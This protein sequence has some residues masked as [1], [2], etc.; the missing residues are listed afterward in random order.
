MSVDPNTLPVLKF[1]SR[2]AA[3]T[4]AKMAIN[5]WNA[6]GWNTTAVY[7][8]LFGPRVKDFQRAHH[9]TAD[10]VIGPATWKALIPH[11]SPAALLLLKPKQPPLVKPRQGF[12]S[13]VEDLWRPYTQGRNAGLS[14]LGTY[15]PASKL[16]SGKPSDHATSRLDGRIGEPACAFDLGFTPVTKNAARA[17]FTSMTLNPAVEYVIME[18]RIWSRDLGLHAYTHG[19]HETHVHVS[20]HRR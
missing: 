18:N 13:L 15:N 10:G 4:A 8:P 20:G 11:L 1:G 9:L 3:V 5:A 12:D 14:D 7:G 16:P 19:G 6:K 2:G 17:F